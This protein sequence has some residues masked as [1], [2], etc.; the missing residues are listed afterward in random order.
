MKVEYIEHMGSDLLVV[1]AARV[2]FDKESV[3]H[4]SGSLYEQDTRLIQFLARGMTTDDFDQLVSDIGG[5][6]NEGIIKLIWEWRRNPTHW[7]PF[8]HPHAT[9]RIKAPIFVARQ[10]AKHQIGMTWSEVSRRYVDE[11]PEFYK[12]E[13]WRKRAENVKQGS[14]EEAVNL[15][16]RKWL[17][18]DGER[19]YADKLIERYL[20]D[21]LDIYRSLLIEGVCPEQ[22]RMVLPQSMMTEWIWTGSLYAWANVYNQRKPG[23]HAQRETQEIARQI[24]DHMAKYFQVS[25]EALTCSD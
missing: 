6:D 20:G 23:G 2:S 24:G 21:T 11:E 22:A 5:S 15:S 4:P 17:D 14:S 12:P 1:N 19:D 3:I 18:V 16:Q 7:A 8:A 25:W 13:V 10:L 9:F